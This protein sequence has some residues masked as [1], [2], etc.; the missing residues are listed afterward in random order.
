MRNKII[1][2]N[3]ITKDF[4]IP[5]ENSLKSHFLNFGKSKYKKFRALSSINFNLEKGDWLGVLGKNGSGKT[6]LLRTIAGI[7]EP[8]E[9]NIAIGGKIAMVSLGTGFNPSLTAKDNI[10]L[11][12]TIL[13]L[14]K[15]D[16]DRKYNSIINFAEVKEFENVPIKNYSSGMKSR[17]GFA[18]A[19]QAEADIYLL[20]EFSSVGDFAFQKKCEKFYKEMKKDKKT[21]IYVTHSVKTIKNYC[22]KV[23]WMEKGAIKT[24][25]ND[26]K[27]ISNMYL[28]SNNKKI[29]GDINLGFYDNSFLK[30]FSK[31]KDDYY[32]VANWIAKNI[33][34]NTFGDIGCGR[35]YIIENLFLLHNKQV[36]GVDGSNFFKK[37]IKKEILPYVHMVDLTKKNILKKADVAICFEV[38]EHIE[39]KY[40][41]ILV[42]NILSTNAKTIL[43]T[44]AQP[45]Q[46]GINHINL[47]PRGYWINKF[48]KKNYALD[49]NKTDKFK[50][51]LRDE[52]RHT[53]WFL[54]N[55]MVFSQKKENI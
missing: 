6:T 39:E 34:G 54:N 44:A 47:K 23:A 37:Y 14:T 5:I 12:G 53:I 32:K 16:I 52:L 55:I 10:Y 1:Q 49:F 28:N 11:S 41:N 43:F 4:K 2:L 38:A 3:N 26:I 27:K 33:E 50:F 42:D 30:L 9:G 17:L 35:G 51:D 40:A 8:T 21:V 46:A 25:G 45:N 7:Y 31:W 13:G 29:S 15:K 18:I 48:R 24:F 20:D 19:I 36:W 22:N